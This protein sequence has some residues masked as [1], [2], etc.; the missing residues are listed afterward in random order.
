GSLDYLDSHGC[1]QR[2]HDLL[3]EIIDHTDYLRHYGLKYLGFHMLDN[4]SELRFGNCRSTETA[5]YLMRDWPGKIAQY[6][7]S[8]SDMD[9]VVSGLFQFLQSPDWVFPLDAHEAEWLFDVVMNPYDREILKAAIAKRSSRSRPDTSVAQ[10]SD[11][12]NAPNETCSSHVAQVQQDCGLTASEP[13]EENDSLENPEAVYE[14]DDQARAI[15]SDS[16]T[17]MFSRDDVLN[18]L[19]MDG[20]LHDEDDVFSVYAEEYEPVRDQEFVTVSE[21]YLQQPETPVVAFDDLEDL[22]L[23]ES[24]SSQD[25]YVEQNDTQEFDMQPES[26]QSADLIQEGHENREAEAPEALD[27]LFGSLSADDIASEE[28]SSTANEPINEVATEEF[29]SEISAYHTDTV[30]TIACDEEP[31]ELVL[32]I[33]QE[34]EQ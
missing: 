19:G 30:E 32:L 12:S 15:E 31:N 11:L 5:E 1:Y 4:V 18:S 20:V 13:H 23:S 7:K 28:I 14:H 3:I 10:P 26:S 34:L 17:A 25:E 29:P 16:P 8:D 24:V 27:S 22:L 6:L 9:A 21:E 2:Y 33:L